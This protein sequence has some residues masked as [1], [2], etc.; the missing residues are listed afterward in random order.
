MIRNF[1]QIE[2]NME[3]FTTIY[4]KGRRKDRRVTFKTT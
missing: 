4:N 2:R 3:M 1:K